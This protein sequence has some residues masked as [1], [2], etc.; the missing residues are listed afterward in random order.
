[1]P[2][3]MSCVL[4]QAHAG[5]P[6][7]PWPG[8]VVLHGHRLQLWDL[9]RCSCSSS[10]RQRN[11]TSA[12]YCVIASNKYQSC[13]T[14]FRQL[15]SLCPINIILLQLAGFPQL[16]AI[17]ADALLGTG[18]NTLSFLLSLFVYQRLL[19]LSPLLRNFSASLRASANSCALRASKGPPQGV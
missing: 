12:P 3:K 8:Q 17:I 19:P 5:L 6:R 14:V 4:R 16:C 13:L 7:S 2:C 15:T 9:S 18:N 11:A 10:G 1:M